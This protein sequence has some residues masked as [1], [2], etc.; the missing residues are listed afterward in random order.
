MRIM[1][2]GVPEITLTTIML[3]VPTILVVGAIFLVRY[4][5]RYNARVKAEAAQAARREE[6]QQSD[7]DRSI[8][9]DL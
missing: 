1:G 2:L 8:I 5:I 7:I 9:N 6:A 3:V 4:F